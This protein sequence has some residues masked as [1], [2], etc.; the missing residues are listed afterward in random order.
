MNSSR[1]NPLLRYYTKFDAI[2]WG[3]ARKSTSRKCQFSYYQVCHIDQS[4]LEY[5]ELGFN[6]FGNL[7]IIRTVT[8]VTGFQY[9]TSEP[10][11]HRIQQK[12]SKYSY[13]GNLFH[14]HLR[15][16]ESSYCSRNFY[17][18]IFALKYNHMYMYKQITMWNATDLICYISDKQNACM[19]CQQNYF[20]VQSFLHGLGISCGSFW[21]TTLKMLH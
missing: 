18:T 9:S 11:L 17:M 10:C 15:A 6:W 16:P 7:V 14:D 12:C 19:C 20:P 3:T 4:K 1:D 5:W 21:P 13:I 8:S 2:K